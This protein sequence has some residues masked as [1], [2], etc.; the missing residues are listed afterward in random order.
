MQHG[1]RCFARLVDVLLGKGA[2]AVAKLG[3]SHGLGWHPGLGGGVHMFDPAHTGTGQHAG[4]AEALDGFVRQ[5]A[6]P[7]QVDCSNSTPVTV[8]WAIPHK[9]SRSKRKAK[10]S[11]RRQP[12]DP[13]LASQPAILPR[14]AMSGCIVAARRRMWSLRGRPRGRLRSSGRVAASS[15][16][17]RPSSMGR[18]GT[19]HRCTQSTACVYIRTRLITCVL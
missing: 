11:T 1:M 10:R 19:S 18:N 13:L 4:T 8:S 16:Q 14:H 6:C 12:G 17:K 15:R 5:S 7:G 9:A 2:A 3:Q